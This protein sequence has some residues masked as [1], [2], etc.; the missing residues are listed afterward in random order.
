V[1]GPILK[2]VGLAATP[3]GRRVIRNAVK[4]ARSEEGKKLVAQAK[5]VAASPEARKL[6]SRAAVTAKHL[7]AVASRPENQ[8]RVKAAA[9]LL[10]K[11]A[12]R[13]G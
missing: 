13:N 7:G 3:T 5:K 9:K 8:Q 10:R 2:G 1:F 12:G 6:A 11:R 4:F